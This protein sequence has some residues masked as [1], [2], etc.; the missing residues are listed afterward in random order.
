MATVDKGNAKESQAIP[1]INTQQFQKL[2]PDPNRIMGKKRFFLLFT[3]IIVICIAIVFTLIFMGLAVRGGGG[4]AY[5]TLIGLGITFAATGVMFAFSYI[6]SVVLLYTWISKTKYGFNKGLWFLPVGT[7]V[8]SFFPNVYPLA[9]A[10]QRTFG[11]YLM[12]V[13][14]GFGLC[15]V[16]ILLL[17]GYLKFK[18]KTF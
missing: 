18:K 6:A 9:Q 17:K 12:I 16:W 14:I 1:S 2:P 5:S 8:L 15:F 4:T 11:N 10:Y 7:G 13:G 3:P